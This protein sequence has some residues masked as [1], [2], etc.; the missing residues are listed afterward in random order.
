MRYD[1]QCPWCGSDTTFR[2]STRP[3]WRMQLACDL[4]SRDMVVTLEGGGITSRRAE[5][6]LSRGESTVRIRLAR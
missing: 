1:F 3:S 2:G 5:G 4:C 6:P